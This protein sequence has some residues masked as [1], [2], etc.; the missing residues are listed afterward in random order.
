DSEP[1]DLNGEGLLIIDND[2]QSL[3]SSL[4]GS[5]VSTD[6]NSHSSSVPST[7][8]TRRSRNWK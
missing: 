5:K 1:K 6:D 3:V 7:R 2:S 4:P 8:N